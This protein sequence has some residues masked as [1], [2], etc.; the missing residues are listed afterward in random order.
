MTRLEALKLLKQILEH[1]N[2]LLGWC[3]AE[4]M[5]EEAKNENTKVNIPAPKAYDILDLYEQIKNGIVKEMTPNTY[6]SINA[7]MSF[8]STKA[9]SRQKVLDFLSQLV[10][11]NKIHRTTDHRKT[12]FYK[13]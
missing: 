13:T 3:V 6:Y 11:E 10:S 8:H 1:K 9:I 12:Y 4:I 5:K 2:N 7:I